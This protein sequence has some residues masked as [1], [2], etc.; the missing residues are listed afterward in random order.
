[1]QEVR[2]LMDE[3]K[4][5]PRAKELMDQWKVDFDKEPLKVRGQRLNAGRI[6]MGGN[7]T[8][9]AHCHGTE[10]DRNVQKAMLG[11]GSL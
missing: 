2:T 4:A 6:M 5:M 1:M 3:I 7:F 10:F 8:F 11:Q 9:D